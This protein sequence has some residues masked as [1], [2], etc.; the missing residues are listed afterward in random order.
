M[1]EK[2][3]WTP[4][5]DILGIK[6]P[7]IQSPMGPFVTT[8]LCAAVSNAGALGTIS[9]SGVGKIL[10]M[11]APELY[12][13]AK[14]SM[15]MPDLDAESE[16]M[17]RDPI[18]ELRK[19]VK[20]TNNPIG[21]NV[22]VS[23]REVDAPYLI[24]MI[25][26]EYENNPEVKKILK[27]V[28]TSAGDPRKFTK[29]LQDVGL[30][31]FHV[32]PSTY[33]AGKALEAGV[34]GVI[35]SGQEAGGHVSYEPVHTSVLLPAVVDFVK[36]KNPDIVIVS[37]GGWC[38]GRG[39]AAALMLGADGIAMGTRFI[40]TKES[41]FALG[42]KE[43]ILEATDRDTIVVPGVLGPIRGIT[44]SYTHLTLPTTERV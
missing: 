2:S 3:I 20:M 6:Y 15:L 25:I 21:I 4:L 40:A 16:I 27:V 37:A 38:D 9:H 7:I 24:D 8:N 12:E 14:K 35:A 26:D 10:K 29:K 43:K 31:V 33:H 11:F 30:L 32:V 17:S 1:P 39:L 19:V 18:T 41:D 44:V 34:N 42:Y 36:K 23:S 5:C 13:T 28:I 22:R